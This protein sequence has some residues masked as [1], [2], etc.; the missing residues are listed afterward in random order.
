MFLA[1][2][3]PDR[4]DDLTSYEYL[5]EAPTADR[6]G[7]QPRWSRQF[8]PTATLFD[9]APNEMSAS[10]NPYLRKYV[11]IHTYHRENKIVART[12]D[13]LTGPWSSPMV[14][15]RPKVGEGD[16]VYAA[17]EH[18]ELASEAGRVVYITFINSATYVPQLIE[19]TWA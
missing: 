5:V 7:V 19:V 9:S 2:T 12:A 14:V 18:P 11:A 13:R 8:Q 16:L 6:P 17:K 15:Y 3:R 10:F 1:R 4:I